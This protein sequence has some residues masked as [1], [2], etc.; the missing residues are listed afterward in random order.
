MYVILKYWLLCGYID[1]KHELLCVLH[2]KKIEFNVTFP[3]N[4]IAN[5]A[6]IYCNNISRFFPQKQ[7]LIFF[8]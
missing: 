4:N 5:S 8:I 2:L 7:P 1:T 6:Y 3:D